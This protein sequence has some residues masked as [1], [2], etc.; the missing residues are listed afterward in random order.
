MK[1]SKNFTKEEYEYSNT[2]IKN[3]IVNK[4]EIGTEPYGNFF[5]LNERLLQP[6]RDF[7]N[8]PIY[9]N[10]GYRCPELNKLVGGVEK[11]QHLGINGGAVDIRVN[12]L[13]AQ[14]LAV[15]ILESGRY[16]DQ[17]ILEKSNGKEWVHLSYN[18]M[19]NRNQT[20]KYENGNYFKW[21][22]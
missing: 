22:L 6:L 14:Q 7:I 12:D 21:V 1:W 17:L 9:I 11:S 2:A 18:H 20:L 3:G 8:K 10:S 15:S 13:T 5:L 19:K 16:F 4:L